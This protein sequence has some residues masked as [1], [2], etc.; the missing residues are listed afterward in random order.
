MEKHLLSS[1]G[2]QVLLWFGRE[3]GAKSKIGGAI[4]HF[5]QLYFFVEGE[6]DIDTR[7]I[8]SPLFPRW[9]D[10]SFC[11]RGERFF[12]GAEILIKSQSQI[13]VFRQGGS[14]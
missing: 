10:Y 6:Y 13:S 9:G 12:R 8:E 11:L 3:S 2:S 5:L 7:A 1:R 4:L 14:L